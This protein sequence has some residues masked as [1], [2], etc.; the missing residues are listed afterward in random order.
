MQLTEDVELSVLRAGGRDQTAGLDGVAARR[1]HELQRALVLLVARVCQSFTCVGLGMS[2]RAAL[3]S[4]VKAVLPQVGGRRSARLLKRFSAGFSAFESAFAKQLKATSL[5]ATLCEGVGAS[6]SA[7]MLRAALTE[8]TAYSTAYQV[9]GWLGS[10][11]LGS[12]RLAWR[13]PRIQLVKDSN[14]LTYLLGKLS[15]CQEATTTEQTW[16]DVADSMEALVSRLSQFDVERGQ[17]VLECVISAKGVLAG[18]WG[19]QHSSA[20]RAGPCPLLSFRCSTMG[21]AHIRASTL[22]GTHAPS[23]RS[24]QSSGGCA[25]CSSA[26]SR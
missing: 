9:E 16:R 7:G 12:L 2:G 5:D 26:R 4:Q 23:T 1:F 13:M 10:T 3:F 22:T 14:E 18:L 25:S 24:P 11:S 6:F 15:A 8:S 19:W 20:Q 17:A 21:R